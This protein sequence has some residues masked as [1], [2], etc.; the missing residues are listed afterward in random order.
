MKPASPYLTADEAAAYLK[1]PTTR[2]F[3]E[4]RRRHPRAIKAYR[5]GSTLLFRVSD[6]DASLDVSRSSLRRVS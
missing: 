3:Y 1:F 4:Y 6:L 2:A 5:R